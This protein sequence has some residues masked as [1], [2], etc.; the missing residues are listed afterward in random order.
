[1]E[2]QEIKQ[3]KEDKVSQLIKDCSMFFA[4]SNEQ[5]DKNKTPLQ[6]GEKYVSLGAGCYMPKGNVEK[7]IAGTKEIDKWYRDTVKANKQRKAN[8]LYELLNHEAFY[9]NDIDDTVEALGSDYTPAEVLEV[10]RA[11]RKKGV[12]QD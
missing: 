3:Q 9:T 1:M 6:E 8:I 10:F 12:T 11:E 2:I 7:W 5:F 4:F